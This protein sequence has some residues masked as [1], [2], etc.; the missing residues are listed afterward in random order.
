MINFGNLSD[1]DNQTILNCF[2]H[3]FS[4][5]SVPFKLNIEQ[6]ETKLFT[7]NINKEF[8]VGAFRENILVGFILHGDRVIGGKRIGYNG[9]TGVIPEER[10]NGLTVKMY[11]Y[12]L[13][14]FK[15][16]G[17]NK[18]ILEVISTNAPAIKCYEKIGFVISRNLDCF[19]GQIHT[20]E[21]NRDI[22]IVQDSKI[23]LKVLSQF[24]E[25]KPTWQNANETI[26]TMA[27]SAKRLLAYVGE[28]LVGFCILNSDNNRIL[29]IAVKRRE[30]HKYVGSTLLE[31]IRKNISTVSSIINVDT[32]YEET[33]NFFG[34]KNL[35]KS[36][37]Q[38]E[39]ELKL[40]VD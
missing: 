12:I 26:S 9:G 1:T 39:M 23:N 19:K 36:L 29:Q 7:E 37:S 18:V 38:Y 35:I 8:S 3:A 28:E 4:D 27:K 33:L 14:M 2:N 24:G 10:G 16:N 22:R 30:R 32:N 15:S 25:I 17:F 31:Y 13:P 40:G 34:S 11:E 21:I 5:Y 6:L 20:G